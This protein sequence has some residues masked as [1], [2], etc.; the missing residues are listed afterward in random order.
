MNWHEITYNGWY[1]IKPNQAKSLP[2]RLGLQN[3]PTAPLQRG[4]TP[5]HEYPGYD[6]KRSDAETLGNAE[7]P[8]IAIA[9]RSTPARNDSTWKAPI[10]GLNRTAYLC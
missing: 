1:A 4:K 3:T 2:I 5:P 6:T 9:P 8:F 10:Y 7:H